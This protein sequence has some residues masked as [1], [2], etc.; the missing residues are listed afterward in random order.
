MVDFIYLCVG[1]TLMDYYYGHCLYYV[2]IYMK[3]AKGKLAMIQVC[4]WSDL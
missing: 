1:L 3:T 4:K 2:Y